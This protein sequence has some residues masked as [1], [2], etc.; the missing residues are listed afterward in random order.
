MGCSPPKVS[1]ALG[2]TRSFFA[3]LRSCKFLAAAISGFFVSVLTM[4]RGARSLS[5]YLTGWSKVLYGV[6]SL[7]DLRSLAF[8]ADS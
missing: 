8:L 6:T 5:F 7:A 3:G 4:L 2:S 1:L